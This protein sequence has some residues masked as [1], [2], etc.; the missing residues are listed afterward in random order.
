METLYKYEDGIITFN[1]LYKESKVN[2]RIYNFKVG[3]FRTGENVNVNGP[4]INMDINKVN[5][6]TE[7]VGISACIWSVYGIMKENSKKTTSAMIIYNTGK[8][9]G[10]KNETTALQQAINDTISKYKKQIQKGMTTSINK[11]KEVMGD[12]AN[13]KINYFVMAAHDYMKFGESHLKYPCVAQ[14]KYDGVRAVAKCVSCKSNRDGTRDNRD[15]N[16]NR[17]RD[18]VMYSRARQP[19]LIKDHI[20]KELTIIFNK[21]PDWF[22]DCELYNHGE[23]LETIVGLVKN[24]DR[25]D[26]LNCYIFD[27]FYDF[28]RPLLLRVSEDLERIKEVI[29]D[30]KLKHIK[31]VDSIMIKN[32]DEIIEF[33]NKALSEKYEGL[34]LKNIDGKYEASI[35]REL[36]SYNILKYKPNYD[37]EFM[38]TNFGSGKGNEEGAILFTMTTQNGMEFT[39]RPFG[40]T[41]DLRK[42]LYKQAIK[43]PKLFIGKEATIKYDSLSIKGVPQRL[44]FKMFRNYTWDYFLSYSE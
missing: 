6:K 29:K 1:T 23:Q 31:V 10:K 3:F 17:D 12:T 25:G 43:Y 7:V 22:L 41:V 26:K 9:I 34:M 36:R 16:S 35:H 2:T 42:E 27:C 21:F 19:F 4:F 13:T 14:R 18:I 39:A 38:V 5:I 15:G 20:K 24:P 40:I 32:K 33:Y 8:N 44:R 37:S 30:N 11:V 28:K